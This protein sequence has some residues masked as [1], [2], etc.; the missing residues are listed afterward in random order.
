MTA[1]AI[2]QSG[3]A[4]IISIPKAILKILGLHIGSELNLSI[5]NSKIVL[6]PIVE[7]NTKELT[8]DDLLAGTPKEAIEIREED[9]EWLHFM[10]RGKEG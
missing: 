1:L 2:R 3:G 7:K 6:T 9:H 8:L 4:G 10:A 5:E